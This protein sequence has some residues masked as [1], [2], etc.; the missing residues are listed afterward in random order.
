M[1]KLHKQGCFARW[2]I[3]YTFSSSTVFFFVEGG[4]GGLNYKICFKKNFRK[5]N[6]LDPY[7]VQHFV[8]PNNITSQ[9]F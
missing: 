8:G 5:S 6:T 2:V 4:G 1:P 7:Q 3:L 9:K